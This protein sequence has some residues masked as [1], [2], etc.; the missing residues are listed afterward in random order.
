[1][2]CG[3]A[4][5]KFITFIFSSLKIQQILLLLLIFIYSAVPGLSCST[6]IFNLGSLGSGM[7]ILSCGMWDLD[8]W[9]TEEPRPLASGAQS[10]SHRTTREVPNI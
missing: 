6:G 10:L 4:K 5:S 1:M 8:P 2:A 7:R 9:L 3:Q